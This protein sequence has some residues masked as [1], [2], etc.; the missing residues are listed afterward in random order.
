[1]F[2]Q[3]YAGCDCNQVN[4]T[5]KTRLL[6]T[7]L[8]LL[9]SF[10][11]VEFAIAFSS[12]SLALVADVGHMVADALAI[13]LA[14]FASWLAQLPASSQATFGYRRVEILA[15]LL[16]GGIL[17]AIALVI[18]IEAVHSLQTPSEDIASLPML[19][20]AITGLV[21]NSLNAAL[22]HRESAHDLNLKG[23][24]LHVVADAISSI[25]VILAA[26]AIGTLHWFW[27]DGV[28]SLLVAGMILVGAIPLIT[29]S[30]QILLEKPSS[31]L[32]VEQIQVYLESFE[33]VVTVEDLK[34]WTVA[35]N[36]EIVCAR[37]YVSLKDGEER[38]RLVQQMQTGLKEKF[39]VQ[40]VVLQM[41]APLPV[42]PHPLLQPELINLI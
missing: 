2:H 9:S 27:A 36:Q 4:G 13:G 25:G 17:V 15:A 1:M 11:L 30:L 21:I 14:L 23:A 6:W 33:A 12:H 37:V 31:P 28:I 22:L 34:L 38:D 35:L 7:V 26:I 39:D 32:K 5:S 16:N 8:I 29:Q 10:S 42:K 24:F 19:I 18:A 3:H 40:E 20:T 41:T